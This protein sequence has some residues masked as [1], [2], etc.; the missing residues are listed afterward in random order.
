MFTLLREIE[1]SIVVDEEGI[2]DGDASNGLVERRLLAGDL[3][4]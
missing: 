1:S 4:G 2:A 3:V